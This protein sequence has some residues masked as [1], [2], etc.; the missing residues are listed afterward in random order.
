M[1]TSLPSRSTASL[2]VVL[3]FLEQG[4]SQARQTPPP[5]VYKPEIAY[6]SNQG[7][8]YSIYVANS[9]GTN[10]VAIYSVK[11]VG[12]GETAFVP[13]S[14]TGSGQLVFI[15]LYSI[16]LLTFTVT[17]S[18]VSASSIVILATEPTLIHYLSVSSVT[19]AG[20][21]VLYGV[22]H[23]DNTTTIKVVSTSGG[24]PTAI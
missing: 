14:G 22:G 10:A 13:G 2:F 6:T 12:I 18:G 16:K 17:P 7:A 21:F 20:Q 23:P 8:T 1:R 3:L 19:A 9:D 24:S 11:G 15:E 4:L 5:A